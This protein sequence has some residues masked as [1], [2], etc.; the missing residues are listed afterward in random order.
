MTVFVNEPTERIRRVVIDQLRADREVV[1]IARDYSRVADL[2]DAGAS[3][4]TLG[5]YG[6]TQA[7][8]LKPFASRRAM[9]R[10]TSG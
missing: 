4:L 1:V 3:V 2:A 9:W 6:S 7:F 5:P 8:L 10:R